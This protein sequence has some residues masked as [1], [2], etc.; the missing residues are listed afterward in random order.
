V[1][2]CVLIGASVGLAAPAAVTFRGAVATPWII[3]QDGQLLVETL[4]SVKNDGEPLKLW[5]RIGLPGKPARVE[6]LGEVA[7]GEAKHTV[8]HAELSAGGENVAFELFADKTCAGEP[9][10]AASVAL[11]KPD[12]NL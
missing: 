2:A 4:L 3:K 12:K 10:A 1:S 5:A 7:A 9:L 6:A 8:R 11:A